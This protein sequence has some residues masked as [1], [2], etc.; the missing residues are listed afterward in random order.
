MRTEASVLIVDRVAA[1]VWDL[2]NGPARALD[3]YSPLFIL[4]RQIPA[5]P[6]REPPP[7]LYVDRGEPA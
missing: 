6:A 3:H 1:L 7:W 4:E 5:T 2:D